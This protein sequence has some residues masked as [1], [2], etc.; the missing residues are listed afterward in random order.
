M[1]QK[2]YGYNAVVKATLHSAQSWKSDL[3]KDKLYFKINPQ[4][5]EKRV[6]RSSKNNFIEP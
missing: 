2:P 5:E 4:P 6:P 3:I 1:N